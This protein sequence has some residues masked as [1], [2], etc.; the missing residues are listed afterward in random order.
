MKNAA[1]NL[2]VTTLEAT[3]FKAVY[4]SSVCPPISVYLRVIVPTGMLGVQ[5]QSITLLSV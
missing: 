4:G 2:P 5:Y 3:R 1:A